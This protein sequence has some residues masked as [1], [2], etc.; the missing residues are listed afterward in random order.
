MHKASH[1]QTVFRLLILHRMTACQYSTGLLYLRSP[2]SQDLSQHRRI[3]AIGKSGDIQRHRR[4][5]SHS[6]YITERIRR[7]YLSKGI[8]I[9]HHRRKKIKSLY[10]GLIITDP[11]DRSIIGSFDSYD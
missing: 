10:H 3:Q 1:T 4:L 5:S 8:G 11:V 7:R 9:I 6:I 2:S